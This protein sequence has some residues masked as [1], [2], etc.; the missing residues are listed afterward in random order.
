MLT[1]EAFRLR[2]VLGG[3]MCSIVLVG[4]AKSSSTVL[5]EYPA[6]PDD[7]P[8]EVISDFPKDRKY[9]EIAL[10]DAKGGQ[11]TFADRSTEAVISMLKTEARKV[12][13]DAVVVRS[14][15]RGNYNWGQGGWDRSK[16]D[17]V[18]IR[19]V[20]DDSAPADSS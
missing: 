18:A 13:A 11:H 15:E 16:A 19:Y 5:K 6:R 17:A 20:T 12:G 1:C 3:V 4:C 14:T 9:V 8:I 7:Y 2:Y 10:L